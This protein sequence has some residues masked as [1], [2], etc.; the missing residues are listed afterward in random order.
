MNWDLLPIF[1]SSKLA[2]EWRI[3]FYLTASS[4]I[5]GAVV[6]GIFSVGELQ[7]WAKKDEGNLSIVRFES[8]ILTCMFLVI[9]II[10]LVYLKQ[11]KSPSSRSEWSTVK[12]LMKR[13]KV[14]IS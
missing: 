9:L 5:F 8:L 7:P 10:V 2:S 11:T 1:V 12:N 6:F 4:A 13:I 3:V 14:L